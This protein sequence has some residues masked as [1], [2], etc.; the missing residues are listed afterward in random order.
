MK[1]K[2]NIVPAGLESDED[3]LEFDDYD[4]S[5]EK[6]TFN[7][8]PHEEDFQLTLR[9]ACINN[10]VPEIIRV[11]NSGSVKINSTLLNCWTCLMYAAS[12][13]S[14]DAVTYL[15]QNGADP[16]LQYDC[17]NI[18]MCICNSS[19]YI[20]IET[21]LLKCLKLVSNFEKID[22]NSKDRSG[23]TALM[24]ASSNGYLK[25]VEFLINNGADIEITDN[26]YGETALF[27]AVRHNHVNVVKY[28][29]SHG[30]NSNATDKK[31]QTVHRIAENKNMTDILK[32]L[33][34][35]PNAEL[36]EYYSKEHTYWDEVMAEMEN[37]FSKDIQLFLENLSMEI[38]TEKLISN[39]VMFKHL[40]SGTKDQFYD[41]GINLLPHR[42][43]MVIALKTFH[44]WNWSN[45]SLGIKKYEMNAD[46]IAQYLAIIVRQLHILDASIMYLGINSL[47]LDK[48]KG[49]EAMRFL[50]T[51][52]ATE[53][54]IFKIL[55]NQM[56]IGKVDYI[57]PHKLKKQNIKINFKDKVFV[58]TVFTLTLLRII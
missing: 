36:D 48:Q 32:L 20:P 9:N 50:M 15:L 46:N 45:R 17:H 38:Y 7:A 44:T 11:L 13:G 19:N 34:I 26:Q 6:R 8:K 3:D 21:D 18:V 39:K 42:K 52:K 49:Q 16:L 2:R 23:L 10:D 35:D 29:L 54:K 12:Y 1:I 25:I 37:G 27:F 58:T 5:I 40:L 53:D 56:R 43:L 24:Y 57:G 28:L 47:N 14:L 4:D 41:M 55:D 31:C 51:I 33:N 22:I 30:A